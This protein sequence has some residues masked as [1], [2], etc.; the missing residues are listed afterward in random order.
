MVS[1]RD[2]QIIEGKAL[3]IRYPGGGGGACI[4]VR[5]QLLFFVEI[6]GSIFFFIISGL[7]YYYFSQILRA[8]FFHHFKGPRVSKSVCHWRK[9]GRPPLQMQP[10]EARG[11]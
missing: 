10:P 5:A 9:W 6:Q 7:N 4:E 2:I 1:R 11:L 8:Q 3:T